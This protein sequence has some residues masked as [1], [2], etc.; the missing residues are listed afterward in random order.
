MLPSP[1]EVTARSDGTT[2][3]GVQ[4]L[5]RIRGADN[6]PDL[7]AVIQERDK[8]FPRVESQ[9]LDSWMLVSPVFEHHI[10]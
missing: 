10:T 7:H 9:A 4:T 3:P 8:Q 1:K 5:D 2:K 6:P